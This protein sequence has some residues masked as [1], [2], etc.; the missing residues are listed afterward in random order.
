LELHP[1]SGKSSKGAVN[2][3]ANK[4]RDVRIRSSMKSYSFHHALISQPD[5]ARREW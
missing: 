5:L 1:K 3:S 4:G 2:I